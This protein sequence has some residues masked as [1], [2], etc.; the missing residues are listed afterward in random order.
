M[1]WAISTKHLQPRMNLTDCVGQGWDLYLGFCDAENC[2]LGFLGTGAGGSRVGI[3]GEDCSQGPSAED[4]LA[5][6]RLL[7][8]IRF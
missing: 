1:A 2:S 5:N 8:P 6:P 3:G 4:H 7:T